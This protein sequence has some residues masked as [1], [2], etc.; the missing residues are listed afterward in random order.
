MTFSGNDL[1][2][3][4]TTLKRLSSKVK[5]FN[6]ILISSENSAAPKEFERD[7]NNI[8]NQFYVKSVWRGARQ[9]GSEVED[10]QVMG[11]M[12]RK[13]FAILIDA[14]ATKSDFTIGTGTRRA[15][16]TYYENHQKQNKNNPCLAMVYVS[17][18]FG[19]NP[20]KMLKKLKVKTCDCSCIRAEN[21][22]HL[23]D[24]HLNKSKISNE[25]L[26]KLFQINR[27]ILKPDIDNLVSC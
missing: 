13:G 6:H 1:I 15:M 7:V 26:V 3:Y 23:L 10:I 5:K 2:V 17:S 18:N 24:K 9:S 8:M 21:L 16:R 20:K 12:K 27:E 4:P 19:G 11:Q 25:K 22:L 14:K